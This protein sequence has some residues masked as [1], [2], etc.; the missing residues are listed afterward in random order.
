MHSYLSY[1]EQKTVTI[2]PLRFR[3]TETPSN[4]R[5]VVVCLAKAVEFGSVMCR[6]VWPTEGENQ[7]A[8]NAA[9]LTQPIRPKPSNK[10]IQPEISAAVPLHTLRWLKRR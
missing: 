6:I 4:P 9:G 3:T 7:T 2:L 1:L 10:L 5:Y 8:I